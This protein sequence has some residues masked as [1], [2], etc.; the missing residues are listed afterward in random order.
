[1]TMTASI[2]DAVINLLVVCGRF[3]RLISSSCSG[4]T[5]LA[6]HYC[7]QEVYR[8]RADIVMTLNDISSISSRKLDGF[9][10]NLAEGQ[11]VGKG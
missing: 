11:G 10:Q 3:V 6:S 5:N 2:H 9:G 1:M 7:Q 8:L 4:L